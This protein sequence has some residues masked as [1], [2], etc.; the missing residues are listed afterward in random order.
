M[1]EGSASDH[2][3]TRSGSGRSSS[4]GGDDDE[5]PH[6][7]EQDHT[8][9]NGDDG[10]DT[11]D[12]DE[13]S[14]VDPPSSNGEDG[15]NSSSDP[16]S[17]SGLAQDGYLGDLTSNDHDNS[18]DE[19]DVISPSILDVNEVSPRPHH[20][21]PRTRARGDE[22]DDDGPPRRRRRIVVGIHCKA[23]SRTTSGALWFVSLVLVVTREDFVKAKTRTKRPR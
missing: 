11:S 23:G 18:D 8:P 4:N 1:G 3:D 7:A 20:F 9:S 22:D 14:L 5:D 10:E 2:D 15:E 19:L 6:D 17:S 16:P 13:D 21:G 12:K